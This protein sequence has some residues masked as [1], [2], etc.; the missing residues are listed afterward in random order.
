MD[1]QELFDKIFASPPLKKPSKKKKLQPKKPP[2][3]TK[4][5]GKATKS[6]GSSIGK[7]KADDSSINSATESTYSTD[8]M[9]DSYHHKPSIVK[10]DRSTKSAPVKSPKFGVGTHVWF[11]LMPFETAQHSVVQTYD[12]TDDFYLNFPDLRHIADNRTR[13]HVIHLVLVR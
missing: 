7:P 2:L 6:G 5:S 1:K 9:D 10:I 11:Q 8:R 4:S 3:D 13:K 12:P